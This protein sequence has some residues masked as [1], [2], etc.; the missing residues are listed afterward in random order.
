MLHSQLKWSK[1]K[2]HSDIVQAKR[3]ASC[4]LK[5]SACFLACQLFLKSIQIE[6]C[7]Y[8]SKLQEI[9]WRQKQWVT[10]YCLDGYKSHIQ[11]RSVI[12]RTSLES[13]L[14]LFICLF[15]KS[16]NIKSYIERS[17]EALCVWSLKYRNLPNDNKLILWDIAQH[18][19]SIWSSKFPGSLRGSLVAAAVAIA[20]HNATTAE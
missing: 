18:T 1:W 6:K 5:N 19:T 16:R 2:L 3:V 8:L 4:K 7:R 9:V 17:H 20:T 13:V 12:H 11:W 15:V 10:L 14:C